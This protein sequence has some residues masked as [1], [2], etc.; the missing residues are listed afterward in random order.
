M[1]NI[2]LWS[3]CILASWAIHAQTILYSFANPQVTQDA[4]TSYYDVDVMVTATA[5]FKMGSGQLYFNYNPAAFGPDIFAAGKVELTHPAGY[6]LGQKDNWLGLVDVYGDFVTNDNTDSR[7]S[8][9]WQQSKEGDCIDE[10]VNVNPQPLFHIRIAFVNADQPPGLCF[11]YGPLFTGQTFTHCGANDGSCGLADEDCITSPGTQLTNE[12]FICTGAALPLDLLDFRIDDYN[13]Q[14]VL[15]GWETIDE[16]NTSHFEIERSVDARTWATIG[17]EPAAG[18]SNSSLKYRFV[19]RYSDSSPAL[20][21][22]LYYRLKM[23]DQDGTFEYSPIR[24]AALTDR[25]AGAFKVFP[26]PTTG[27]IHL[28]NDSHFADAKEHLIQLHHP[29]G[30]LVFTQQLT[31]A[32]RHIELPTSLSAGV[33]QLRIISEE[34]QV[35]AMK[36]ITLIR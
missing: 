21:G 35:L 28:V 26:N 9:S 10:N 13:Q 12:N 4:D 5:P 7:F 32:T 2:I 25:G 34:A 20:N 31:D 14:E 6:L 17:E 36:R 3:W 1:K 27:R 23:V 33:Y 18:F 8:Y 24:S 16:V 22:S 15:L 30:Q 19:D 29:N 11:E